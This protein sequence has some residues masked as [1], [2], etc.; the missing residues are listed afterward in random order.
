[1]SY[2][3]IPLLYYGDEIGTLNELT[4]LDD[5][6]KVGDIQRLL[7]RN[8]RSPRNNPTRHAMIVELLSYRQRHRMPE[9]HAEQMEEQDLAK[10]LDELP[11]DL[12]ESVFA[13]WVVGLFDEALD[14]IAVR[15][16]LMPIV[17]SMSGIAGSQ[18]L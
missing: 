5:E 9:K 6:S 15:A 8:I 12:T 7:C 10:V 1:M 16:V 3:G 18:T 17:A 2:G 4:Y 11:I 13:A 14:K